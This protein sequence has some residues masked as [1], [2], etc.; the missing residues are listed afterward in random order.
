L[1]CFIYLHLYG[2]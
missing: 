2:T 1:F